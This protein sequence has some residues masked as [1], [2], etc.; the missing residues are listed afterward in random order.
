MA[1]VG[2]AHVIVR[3]ITT[4]VANDIK[5]GFKDIDG[6]IAQSA[7]RNLG[8]SFSRGWSGSKGS[9]VFTRISEGLLD[10]LEH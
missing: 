2:E 8:N 5:N 1:V 7:G 3:A 4:G 9:N 6:R 10:N